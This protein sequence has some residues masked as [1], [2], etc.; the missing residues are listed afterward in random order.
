MAA[1]AILL[2]LASL[3]QQQGYFPEKP[4][5]WQ[6]K[7]DTRVDQGYA[8]PAPQAL[9]VGRRMGKL[10]DVLHGA[11]V[12]QPPL[13]FQPRARARSWLATE[14]SRGSVSCRQRAVQVQAG[15]TLYYFVADAQGQPTFG[16]EANTSAGI[17]VNQPEA[18]F[19]SAGEY[20]VLGA[21]YLLL[22]DGRHVNFQPT[23]TQDLSGFPLYD[24]QLLVITRGTRPVWVPVTRAQYLEALIAFEQ[25]ELARDE[26]RLGKVS[27][28][29]QKFVD[30]R[31]ARRVAREKTYQALKASSPA[32]AEEFL[33]TSLDMDAKMDAG[34]K[35]AA[36]SVAMRGDPRTLARDIIQGLRGRLAQMPAAERG[37]QAWLAR[38]SPQ[39][40]E[41]FR[42]LV[43]PGTA[44]ARPLV[45]FNPD[46]FDRTLPRTAWQLLT[47]H[48][49]S[50]AQYRSTTF[51][52]GMRLRQ[53]AETADWR[54][55]AGLLAARATTP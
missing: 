16:G 12:F 54:A 47:V 29:Y 27:D 37:Q 32:R 26:E 39:E 11:A 51:I 33:R 13:G 30:E 41:Y 44:D 8:I 4:G 23:K 46:F 28:P 31:E 18:T 34:L 24:D 19:V 42:P 22:P 1:S 5:E 15:V 17:W 20:D 10:L 6:Q 55:V 14:C 38:R 45:A 40:G 52:G 9:E 21:P 2:V 7:V 43:P 25:R 49:L 35:A 53:F 36:P 50:D 3:V 48:F